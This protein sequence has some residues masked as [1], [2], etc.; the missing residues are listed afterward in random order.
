[1]RV[2]VSLLVSASLTAAAA[3][4]KKAAPANNTERGILVRRAELYIQADKNS[5]R[6]GEIDRGREVAVIDRSREY[7]EVFANIGPEKD[8][9]GWIL[10]KGVIEKNTPDGDRVLFGE[11]SDSEDQAESAHGRRG[12]AQEAIRL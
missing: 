9:T 6:I 7:V 5:T 4:S 1:M 2:L 11:A 12:A 10:N 8:L 3:Q